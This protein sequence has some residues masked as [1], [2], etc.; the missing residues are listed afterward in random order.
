MMEFA[1]SSFSWETKDNKHLLGRTYDQFGDL[2]GNN[3]AIIP[4]N[5]ELSSLIESNNLFKVKYNLVGMN[6]TGLNTP[7]LVDGINE[8][9]LM[10]ALL[11]YPGYAKYDTN[12]K[13]GIRN[14]NPG[15]FITYMLS[16]CSSVK[17]VINEIEKVNLCNEKVFGNEIP[18]HYIFSDKTGKTIIIEPDNNKVSIH[19]DNIGV[20]T[21]SP[22]Y[23]WHEDN[24]RNYATLEPIMN[25]KRNICGKEFQEFGYSSLNLPGGYSSVNRFVKIALMKEFTFK[26]EN[27]IEGITKMFQ[28]FSSVD[29]PYGVLG[30]KKANK[31]DY[32]M[33]L[34]ITGMCSESATYYFSLH[35]NRRINA[36]N[37]NNAVDLNSIKFIELP[38][39]QD[40]SY[41]L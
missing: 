24:L 29:I 1:C 2:K 11:R 33:T 13:D 23:K 35:T 39:K 3:I 19:E 14:I 21:N 38:Y 12:L 7:L 22:N 36:I 32:Q 34:C 15:F 41:L 26:G 27:E 25:V 6:I 4:K 10:G 28:N 9:G 30:I 20:L 5:Y 31:I 37:L 16:N 18:V 8:I 40:V 17:E